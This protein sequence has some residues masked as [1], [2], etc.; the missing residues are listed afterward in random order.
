MQSGNYP[1][2]GNRS[3][4]Q[5]QQSQRAARARR[6]A[7]RRAAGCL[8]LFL[9]LIGLSCFSLWQSV[10][11]HFSRFTPHPEAFSSHEAAQY[12]DLFAGIS[13]TAAVLIELD[14]GEQLAALRADQPMPPASLTKLMTVFAA[15]HL[16]DDL[17]QSVTLNSDLFPP[18]WEENA[19]MAGF[20]P[21]ET[22][23]AQELLYGALLP[24]GAE[25]CAGLAE[26]VGGEP[27]LLE[28]M[29][30]LAQELG[31]TGSQF[32]NP[33]GLDQAGHQ[34][35]AADLALLLR[36]ALREEYEPFRTIFTSWDHQCAGS[37][38]HPDGLL[39]RSTLAFHRD[40]LQGDGWQV[41]GTKTGFTDAAGL[42]LATLAK[43][44][45]AEYLLVTL[46][47]PGA[48]A[49]DTAHIEDA[50]LVWS[51][52]AAQIEQ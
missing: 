5:A 49:S 38:I 45:N 41:L 35:T 26:A 44:G 24:S 11:G 22:V 21:G 15:L 17:Q 42:C 20:L 6:Q 9:I 2:A 47:A 23:R 10:R 4:A 32:E 7:R 29:N 27:V 25:C 36:E 16:L 3:I 13:S 12:S 51:R 40:Q 30:R 43:V 39:L 18:L 31:M 28:E 14:S 1:Y 33:T 8:F 52:L 34:S 50:A 48:S 19:S 37:D 46:G